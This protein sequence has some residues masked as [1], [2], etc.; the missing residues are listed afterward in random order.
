MLSETELQPITPVCRLSQAV[1]SEAMTSSIKLQRAQSELLT[2]AAVL[3]RRQGAITYECW[4]RLGVN[5][6]VEGNP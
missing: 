2:E 5:N 3:R 6:D 1:L 4:T